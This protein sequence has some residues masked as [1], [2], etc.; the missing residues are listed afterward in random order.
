MTIAWSN[1]VGEYHICC[2]VEE[3]P[4]EIFTAIVE[5]NGIEIYRVRLPAASNPGALQRAIALR[6]RFTDRVESASEAE[7]AR[8]GKIVR[9]SRDD[10]A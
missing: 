9:V 6:R 8:L 7:F 1:D 2:T 3:D 10:I 4:P 5:E